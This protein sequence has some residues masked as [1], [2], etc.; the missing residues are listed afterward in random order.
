MISTSDL[1]A[2]R[3]LQEQTMSEEALVKRRTL[4]SDGAGGTTETWATA[5]TVD[6]RIAPMTGRDL[7]MLGGR[8]VEGA[9]MRVTLPALT[10]VRTTDRL[11]VGSRQF[12][13]LAVAGHSWETARVVVCGER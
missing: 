5:A 1:A 11:Y 13:V 10:D 6:C 2:M 4:A 8:V 3:S 12:E 9:T 7:A